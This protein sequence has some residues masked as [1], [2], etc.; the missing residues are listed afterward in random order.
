MPKAILMGFLAAFV[1]IVKAKLGL[2]LVFFSANPPLLVTGSGVLPGEVV[3]SA[4]WRQHLGAE[5]RCRSEQD[6]GVWAAAGSQARLT[7]GGKLCL[8]A[9]FS[10]RCISMFLYH[11]CA[12]ACTHILQWQHSHRGMSK[13]ERQTP[14]VSHFNISEW[15]FYWKGKTRKTF[16]I[17]DSQDV[18]NRRKSKLGE[19]K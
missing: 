12:C 1:N 5:G 10:Y 8:P 16:S 4:L 15:C 9:F 18:L 6:W 14:A 17:E 11:S 3:L 19:T 2:T 7:Q 13:L